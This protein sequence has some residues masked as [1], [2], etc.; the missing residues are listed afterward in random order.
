MRGK[1]C[2][3]VEIDPR[4]LKAERSLFSDNKVHNYVVGSHL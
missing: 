3:G 1:K 4:R 2:C